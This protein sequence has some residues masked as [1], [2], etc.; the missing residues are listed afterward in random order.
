MSEDRLRQRVHGL[1][2]DPAQ[3]ERTADYLPAQAQGDPEGGYRRPAVAGP[4]CPS[5][6][7]ALSRSVGKVDGRTAH[8]RHVVPETAEAGAGGR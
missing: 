1:Q 2:G 7:F 3:H 4:R 5:A 6:G 8:C